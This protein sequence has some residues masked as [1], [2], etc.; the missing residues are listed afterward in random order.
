MIFPSFLIS[1]KT[2]L[3]RS[4]KSPRYFAPASIAVISS[5]YICFVLSSAGT[6]PCAILIARPSAIAVLPTPGSPT[7]QGLFFDR[8]RSISIT[9]AVSFSRHRHGSSFPLRAA[10]VSSLPYFVSVEDKPLPVLSLPFPHCGV[11]FSG[12]ALLIMNASLSRPVSRR[13]TDA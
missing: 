12:S 11:F 5:I 7:R 3:S 8:L 9:L 6:L 10:A 13:N 2:F 1:S 4:S